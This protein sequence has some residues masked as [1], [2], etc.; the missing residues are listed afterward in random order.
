MNVTTSANWHRPV[1]G[2]IRVEQ[3]IS[4]QLAAMYG[5]DAFGLGI[6]EGNEFVPVKGALRR[7]KRDE[8]SPL[9][10][11]DRSRRSPRNSTFDPVLGVAR[12]GLTPQSI[13]SD[14]S[15]PEA[16]RFDGP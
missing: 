5:P 3:E 13:G 8:S 11:P 15:V 16:P 14:S 9:F 1:V 6:F 10:W 7:T 2:I 12:R 4:R